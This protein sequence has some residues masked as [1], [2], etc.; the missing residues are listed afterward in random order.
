[1]VGGCFGG[2]GELRREEVVGGSGRREEAAEAAAGGARSSH[3][4]G[5]GT[6]RD[7]GRRKGMKFLVHIIYPVR[8]SSYKLHF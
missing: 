4:P 7:D 5:H 6:A 8:R 1:M 3:G 2:G